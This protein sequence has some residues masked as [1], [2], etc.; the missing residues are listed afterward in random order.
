MV[1]LFVILDKKY[2]MQLTKLLFLLFFVSYSS[3]FS[4]IDDWG[5]NGHRATGKIAEQ[6]LSKRVLKKI[7]KILDGESLAFVSTF[8]D[9]IKSD[10]KYRKFSSWHYVNMPFDA[11]YETSDKN[12]KGDLITGIDFCI[13]I[14]KD[15]TA[16]KKD[17]KF[18]LKMLVHLVGDLHQPLHVG[19]REDKGGNTIQLQWFGEGTN[20]HKVWDHNMLESWDMSYLEL[21]SNEAEL[22]KDEIKKIK[23]GTII[24]WLNDTHKLTEKVYNSVEI[25]ENLK[26][27]YSYDFFPVVRT[28]LQKGGIRLAKL[29]ED[30]F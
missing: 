27:R 18:Y 1:K 5:A 2:I 22:S 14:L 9:E 12:P 21:A 26:Y 8:S 30:I 13:K 10:K 6:H 25:G 15:K 19:R 11:K 24:D 23:E 29:L 3:V 28:Q 7:N 16:S 20:L 17:K 4:F